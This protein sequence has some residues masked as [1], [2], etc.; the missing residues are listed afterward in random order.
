MNTGKYYRLRGKTYY[1]HR[2]IPDDVVAHYGN[3]KATLKTFSLKTSIERLAIRK[4]REHAVRMDQEF[5]AIRL[6]ILTQDRFGV[7]NNVQGQPAFDDDVISFNDFVPLRLKLT[8]EAIQMLCDRWMANVLMSDEYNR[9]SG[10]VSIDP[11]EVTEGILDTLPLFKQAIATG[12]HEIIEPVVQQWLWLNGYQAIPNDPAY[13]SLRWQLLQTAFKA[14]QIVWQRQQGELVDIAQHIPASQSTSCTINDVEINVGPAQAAPS[15]NPATPPGVADKALSLDKVYEQWLEQP[16]DRAKSTLASM[17]PIISAMKAF[18]DKA[19]LKDV[20]IIRRGMM[21][22][23]C[24]HLLAQG[25]HFRTVE[26]KIALI[27]A[28]FQVAMDREQIISNPASR[29]KV[30]KPKVIKPSRVSFN[31]DDLQRIFNSGIYHGDIP[32]AGAG[33]AAIWLPILGMYTGA[34]VEELAQLMVYDVKQDPKH[35]YYFNI[36]DLSEDGNEHIKAV[37]TN[38]SRR[39]IPLHPDLIKIGFLTYWEECKTQNHRQLFPLLKPD[40]HNKLSGNWSKWWSRYMRTE[41]GITAKSKVFH[42]FRHT[43]KDACREAGIGEEI[44]DSLTGHS[45]GGVG[46]GYGDVYSLQQLAKAIGSLQFNTR[47]TDTC[48]VEV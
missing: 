19:C 5:H 37:K 31:Q 46:R 18:L 2:R 11:E 8:P 4:A 7:A 26:K 43:F 30:A 45:G 1:F 25:Q 44:H 24:D 48:N 22:E 17:P 23:F 20:R 39:R 9:I 47:L 33:A 3:G 6:G 35:G 38:T 42:S 34:R 32:K 41:I 36:T 40:Q 14:Q 29:I 15:Q 27:S 21:V 12:K 13:P 16:K 28:I 10:F